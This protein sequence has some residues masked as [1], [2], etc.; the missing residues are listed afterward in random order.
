M[1]SPGRLRLA[2]WGDVG[3]ADGGYAR[4]PTPDDRFRAGTGGHRPVRGAGIR[5]GHGRRDRGGGPHLAPDVLPVLPEQGGRGPRRRRQ[6]TRPLRAGLA[7]CSPDEPVL[8]ALRNTVLEMSNEFEM[9]RE[10]YV[11]RWE[12]ITDCPTLGARTGSSGTGTRPSVTTSPAG[13][14]STPTRTCGRADRGH[15]H[16]LRAATA[17]WLLNEDFELGVL[18]A[19]AFDLITE[20]LGSWSTGSEVR[21]RGWRR[22]AGG[23]R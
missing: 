7:A 23:V 18:M 11:R 15:G 3:S 6:G 19:E 17:P 14:G 4:A 9:G 10:E 5:L 12:I 2:R 20:G 8:A 16:A 13:S 22:P 1:R 21:G